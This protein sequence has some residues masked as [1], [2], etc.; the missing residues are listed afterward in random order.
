MLDQSLRESPLEN[1]TLSIGHAASVGRAACPSSSTPASAANTRGAVAAAW[2]DDRCDNINT[3][4]L[5]TVITPN[6]LGPKGNFPTSR[7]AFGQ[8]WVPGSS[9]RVASDTTEIPF[10]FTSYLAKLPSY[11]LILISLPKFL[12]DEDLR[13]DQCR[14]DSVLDICHDST[15]EDLQNETE[16]CPRDKVALVIDSCIEDGKA[17]FRP[18]SGALSPAQLLQELLK[19]RFSLNPGT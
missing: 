4:H 10:D 19:E 17:K 1:D 2:K 11:Q 3:H 18:G 12:T 7:V 6:T 5:A 8:Y 14:I 9:R 16:R 15:S 13:Q